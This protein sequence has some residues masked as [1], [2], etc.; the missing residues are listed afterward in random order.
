MREIADQ[1]SHDWFTGQFFRR[2]NVELEAKLKSHASIAIEKTFNPD[3]Y[4]SPAKF[5]TQ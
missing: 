5:T 2:H 1:F 4:R 3:S